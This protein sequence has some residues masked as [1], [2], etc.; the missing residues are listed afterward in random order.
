MQPGWLY[1]QRWAQLAQRQA[2]A[3]SESRSGGAGAA[4]R[5]GALQAGLSSGGAQRRGIWS[6]FN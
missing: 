2:T 1:F 3:A 5:V 4:A 6:L